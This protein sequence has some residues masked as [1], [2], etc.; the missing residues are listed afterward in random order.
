MTAV[1]RLTASSLTEPHIDGLAF[2]GKPKGI[3]CTAHAAHTAHN[4]EQ[5]CVLLYTVY[6]THSAAA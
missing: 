6:T 1:S 4:C 5:H 3:V 2:S